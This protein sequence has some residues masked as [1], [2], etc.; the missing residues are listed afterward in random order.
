LGTWL[1]AA[2]VYVT[3]YPNLDQIVS[4]TLAYAMGAGKAI[5]S[6]PYAY[7]SEM[8]DLGRGRLVEPGSPQAL[9]EAFVDL[10]ENDALRAQLGR[11]AH[12]HSRT[13]LWDQVGSRYQGI[14]ARTVSRARPA[15][16]AVGLG[17]MDG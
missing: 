4:G 3:P 9:S 7:A 2:D 10:L 12:Q 16:I 6:T 14:F 1:K 13:M 15:R 5:V 8:L 17:A 11:L